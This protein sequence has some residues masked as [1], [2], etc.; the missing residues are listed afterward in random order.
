MPDNPLYTIMHPSSVV[1]AGASNNP[2]KMGSIQAQ[3]LVNAGYKG[4]VYFLH[5]TE[6]EVLG[7]RAYPTPDELPIAPELALLVTPTKVTPDLID[8]LGKRGTRHAVIVTAG[9]REVGGSG[10][11]LEADLVAAAARHDVRFIG[12]NCIGILNTNI[13]LNLTV[14][15][16]ADRPGRLS[17]ISQS[18]TY[19]AQ[20]MP[21]L[22]ERG[23]RYSQ[24]L[25]VGNSTDIDLVDCLEYLGG[26]ED[27]A[28]IIM[29]IEEIRRGRLFL[30]TARQVA[31]H[32]PLVALYV[33]GTASG[34]RSGLSHTGSLGAPDTL[35]DG[36]FEQAG[37]IRARTV[38]QLFEWGHTLAVMPVS[39]GNR[40]AILTHSGGPATS[41]ADVC[42]RE[43][44]ALP[45]FSE[46]LQSQIR[47]LIEPTASARNPVDLTF[48]MAHGAF[49]HKIPQ[50]LFHSDE[51]DGVL[52]HGMMDS[53]FAMEQYD[54]IK[55]RL[56][57]SK[58]EYARLMVFDL[59]RL[60]KMPLESGKPL[61][62][63]SFL[64]VDHA[65][66]Y[67]RDNDIP[68]MR[69]PEAAVL[70][71]S[72]LVR[73]GAIRRRLAQDGAVDFPAV[74]PESIAGG[75]KKRTVLDEFESKRL[76]AQY[77]VPI[78]REYK[79]KSL[80]EA[81]KKAAEIGYPIV[82]KGLPEG[83]THKTEAALVHL[84]ITS[85]KALQEAWRK[86]EE[87]APRCPRLLAGMVRGG[88]ELVVGMTR[89]RGFGPCVMLGLGGILT[90]AIRDVTFRAV[91]VSNDEAREMPD[92][93]QL[94]R[95]FEA[96]RGMPE[97]DR[98]ILATVITG[99]GKLA[100]DHPEI[101]EID[102][103]PLIVCDGKP[104]TVDALVVMEK[105]E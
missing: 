50:I 104:I 65:A 70:A 36:I 51:I 47:P 25:S 52:I 44:L 93:L 49:V 6:K 88:R 69:Y 32:K 53:G 30:K 2:M 28:A 15:P 80:A 43:G 26:C 77:G 86:I 61:V 48:S 45:P 21:Y 42:D 71:M 101:T 68:L 60:V 90:E 10:P 37:V 13:G 64:R 74:L 41:M 57:I 22:R 12:P 18:G 78:P 19:V 76:L 85:T 67:F 98:A 8:K 103:N 27:T 14:L 29:Y 83:V 84:G 58:E 40:I 11:Q 96:Q 100:L 34:A 94:K 17:L 89:H 39:K 55:D 16:Y 95:L 87:A 62:T 20:L 59:S 105:P 91:P 73:Y 31:R 72:A 38:E 66:E 5:P 9:F 7:H 54:N 3:N 56:N 82:L 81:K 24:A 35:I 92:S 23:I 102:I 75:E 79:V 33:G 46:E 4:E 97:I 1:V 63:S 99:V